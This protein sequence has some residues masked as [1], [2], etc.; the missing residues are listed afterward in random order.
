MGEDEAQ[1]L[2][3]AAVDELEVPFEA[4]VVRQVEFADPG[5]V[6]AAAKILQEQGVIEIGELLVPE[7]ERTADRDAY[8]AAADAMA[9][10]LALGEVEG[11]AEGAEDLSETNRYCGHGRS[12]LAASNRL[13]GNQLGFVNGMVMWRC[14]ATRLMRNAANFVN[15]TEGSGW[16]YPDPRNG[17][18][19]H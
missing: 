14:D 11:A 8:P 12:G 15:H 5:G 10:R 18:S 4:Q 13:R 6:A 19:L 2:R 9:G 16:F 7:I 3:K 1:D 17:I